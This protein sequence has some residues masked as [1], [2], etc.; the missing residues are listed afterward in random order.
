MND[1]PQNHNAKIAQ[2]STRDPLLACIILAIAFLA[3]AAVRLYNID[4]AKLY[5]SPTRQYYSFCIARQFYFES[6]DSVPDWQRQVAK[7]NQ[8]GRDVYRPLFS[9][10]NLFTYNSEATKAKILA[11]GCPP[12]QMAKLPMGINL[13]RIVFAE[14]KAKSFR[15][16]RMRL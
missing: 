14:G 5:F 13:D 2:S 15:L 12:V 10:G 3:A 9:N 6:I 7:A 4:A 8:H 11:L 1:A 16:F